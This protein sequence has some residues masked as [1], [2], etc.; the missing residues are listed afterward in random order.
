MQGPSWCVLCGKAEE[1]MS[2]LLD[3]CEFS[4]TLWDKGAQL[5]RRT[6]RRRGHPELSIQQWG[7]DPF[8]NSILNRLWFAFPGFL[9]WSIWK[10]RNRRIFELKY[11]PSDEVWGRIRSLMIESLKLQSWSDQDLKAPAAESIILSSWGITTLPASLKP[12]RI[13]RPESS[14]PDS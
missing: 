12:N 14:S 5:F 3:A 9:L 1:T 7:E 13:P 11:K 2:H 6:D 10:E 4:S 8:S